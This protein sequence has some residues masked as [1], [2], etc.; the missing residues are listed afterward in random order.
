VLKTTLV[1]IKDPYLR[2]AFRFLTSSGP[3]FP[4]VLQGND[5]P[6]QDKIGFACRFLADDQ[7]R[8]HPPHPF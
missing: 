4:E 5:L 6:M 1:Q 3:P 8:D 7:V 2:A